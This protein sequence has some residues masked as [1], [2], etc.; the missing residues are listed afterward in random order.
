MKSGDFYNLH[1]TMQ[2]ASVEFATSWLVDAAREVGLPDN[3]QITVA[4]YGASQGHNSMV[5]M[6]GAV[7]ALRERTDAP[8]AVVH[9]DLPSNDFSAIFKAVDRDQVSYLRG[10]TDVFPYCI[11]R[12]FYSR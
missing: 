3:G 7:A 9:T 2:M 12:S 5:P 10:H 4:D 6:N 11:G 8:I 1:S